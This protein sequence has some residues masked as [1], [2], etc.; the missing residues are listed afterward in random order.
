SWPASTA[1]SAKRPP[2]TGPAGGS[3][4]SPATTGSPEKSASRSSDLPHSIME[5]FR[6][7][8]GN[9]RPGNLGNC[10]ARPFWDMVIGGRPTNAYLAYDRIGRESRL[11]LPFPSWFAELFAQVLSGQSVPAGPMTE[12]VR[13]LV[14]GRVDDA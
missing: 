9:I 4:S 3:L 6:A 11:E 14:A 13:D 8:C 2:R 12:A 1:R 7:G 5:G 10:V